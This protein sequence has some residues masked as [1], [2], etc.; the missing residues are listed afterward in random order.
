[1]SKQ[2]D[3]SK[4]LAHTKSEEE[5][6]AVFIR[7]LKLAPAM[8]NRTDL[9]DSHGL[10]EFKYCKRLGDPRVLAET[11]AQTCYY[12][13]RMQRYHGGDQLPAKVII[14]DKNE[15]SIC[16]V[17]D[18]QPSFEMDID[19]DAA[20]SQPDI[21]LVTALIPVAAGLQVYK[22]TS[23]A[24]AQQFKSAL[25]SQDGVAPK[26]IVTQ[27]NFEA[28]FEEWKDCIGKNFRHD[29][30]SWVFMADLNKADGQYDNTTGKLNV[31]LNSKV[32]SAHV[33]RQ[34]YHRFWG[35]W[36]RP[37]TMAV[38]Q[39]MLNHA[40]RLQI[41]D[42]RRI[43]GQF[44][45]ALPI[46]N[47]ALGHLAQILGQD[48]ADKY[49]I[50]DPCAGTGNLTYYM[51][52]YD[53]CFVSTVEQDEVDYIQE[54]GLAP[55]A[56]VFQYDYCN[57]D[58]DKLANGDAWISP[59]WKMPLALRNV[60]EHEP[61]KLIVLM[62][63]P[64]A[65]ATDATRSGA[66]KTGVTKALAKKAFGDAG[67]AQQ[68]LFTQ[69]LLR[70]SHHKVGHMGVFSKLKLNNTNGY[71]KVRALMPY[72]LQSGFIIPSWCFH[73]TTGKFPIGFQLLKRGEPGY[74]GKLKVWCGKTFDTLEPAGEKLVGPTERPA[75]NSWVIKLENKETR[76]PVKSGVNLAERNIRCDK[77]AKSALG[78]I[79]SAGSDVQNS[80]QSVALFSS[81]FSSGNG[82][83]V[84]PEN[85]WQTCACFAVR[86]AIK[87]TWLNDRDQFTW[88]I[89]EPSEEFYTRCLVYLLFHGSNQTSSLKDVVYKG[90]T[91]QIRNPWFPYY[92]HDFTDRVTADV[93]MYRQ[94]SIAQQTQVCKILGDRELPTDCQR[95]MLAG[96]QVYQ[97][98]F[99]NLA[100]LDRQSFKIDYWDQG[101]YQIRKSLEA[102]GLATPEL[103]ELKSGHKELQTALIPEIYKLG[104]IRDEIE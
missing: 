99:E 65:A 88:P 80:A 16:T 29:E 17:V 2:I 94:L 91:Y 104:F 14:A 7:W 49:W 69:F 9:V 54:Y 103:Q 35:I 5:V 100:S 37:P 24:E 19:W 3:L 82:W 4:L 45:T 52:R 11:L 62:N 13:R 95:V 10:W 93:G 85:F 68:E 46:A 87:P 66:V 28:A 67:R 97:K 89:E 47:M 44:Y 42:K 41:V 21:S 31:V 96:H 58:V 73:G 77:L 81:P 34:E 33:P 61:E 36:H 102:Q 71:E 38:L 79:N 30:R 50:W 74:T 92:P 51:P 18:L 60:L 32:V 12:I 78:Y 39:L 55:G 59:G 27:Y 98:F 63:P 8:R 84:T 90:T 53:R 25:E 48:F 101:W 75:L 76:P 56:Q 83:S 15:A 70:S 86:K 6:K 57:D 64:Y 1:M 43:L 20:A 26:R 72:S 22:L 40:D 23:L